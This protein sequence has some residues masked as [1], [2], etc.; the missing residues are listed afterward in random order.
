MADINVGAISEALNNKADRDFN[1]TD[2]QTRLDNK[3]NTNLSNTPFASLGNDNNNLTWKGMNVSGL[4]MPDYT[5]G[6]GISS[7]HVTQKNGY[8]TFAGK[9]SGGACILTIDNVE[10]IKNQSSY[11]SSQ[12]PFRDTVA[13]AKGST[14][15]WSGGS[16][17]ATFYPVKGE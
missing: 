1:N 6:V 15:K 16:T 13:V 17:S 12:V 11:G 2:V 8:I 5:R 4:G 14:I 7:G 3:A 10:I 9:P